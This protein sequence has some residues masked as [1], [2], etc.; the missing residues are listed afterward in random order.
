M[1]IY[2]GNISWDTTETSL[3]R[4]FEQYGQVASARIVMDRDTGRSRGFAFVEMPNDDE[5]RAAVEAMNGAEL[6]GRSVR[7]NE[8]RP[9]EERPSRGPRY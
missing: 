6:D 3:Q 4:A 9:R 1:N 2:V 5:G 7:V 8:A